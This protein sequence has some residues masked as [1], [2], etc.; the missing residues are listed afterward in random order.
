MNSMVPDY[1]DSVLQG[2]RPDT[3]GEPAQYI[4]EL[5]SADPDR[6]AAAFA[7]LDGEVY[8][9][10]DAEVEFTIQSISK[11]FVYALALADRGFDV[12]DDKVGVEPS[13]R[14][15]TRSRSSRAPGAPATP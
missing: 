7:T 14:R 5:A 13:G 2:V 11:P 6:M 9:S 10:G 12:V 1:L 15:S 8:G 4:P 3:S